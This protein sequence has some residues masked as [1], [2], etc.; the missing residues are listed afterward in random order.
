MDAFDIQH[1]RTKSR[2]ISPDYPNIQSDLQPWEH[3][4]AITS[5]YE[6]TN[7][8]N[9]DMH[10]FCNYLMKKIN[11]DPEKLVAEYLD[12]KKPDIKV[13]YE[14]FIDKP[15]TGGIWKFDTEMEARQFAAKHKNISTY[16]DR[17]SKEKIK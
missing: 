4:W 2:E 7:L 14:V 10:K 11:E 9:E 5:A 8:A 1:L 16:I 3:L 13:Q 6:G 12:G 15:L 17:V